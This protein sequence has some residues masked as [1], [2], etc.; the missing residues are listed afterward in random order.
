MH[1]QGERNLSLNKA[2]VHKVLID[3][4]EYTEKPTT[5]LYKYSKYRANFLGK[6]IY[7]SKLKIAQKKNMEFNLKGLTVEEFIHEVG[8]KDLKRRASKKEMDILRKR[9]KFT[10]QRYLT[11]NQVAKLVT[12]GQTIV[13]G[14]FKELNKKDQ[15]ING[16]FQGY[17]KS[18]EAIDFD[19]TQ[20]V[21]LDFDSNITIQE[22]ISIAEKN[23]LPIALLY[24]TFS[25]K[26]NSHKFRI[27]HQL[28]YKIKD[29]LTFKIVLKA[30]TNVYLNTQDGQVSS[31]INLIFGTRAKHIILDELAVISKE[32][33]HKLIGVMVP[34]VEEN[35]SIF[36]PDVIKCTQGVVTKTAK[37]IKSFGKLIDVDYK[38]SS[39]DEKYEKLMGK[40]Y[41]LTRF[42]QGAINESG[43]HNK[44][45]GIGW[46]WNELNLDMYDFSYIASLNRP[47][48]DWDS[49]IASILKKEH[50][51][52]F[53]ISHAI[54]KDL[55][56]LDFT[57]V[58][59]EIIKNDYITNQLRKQKIKDKVVRVKQEGRHIES[60]KSIIDDNLSAWDKNKILLI[61]DTG[62]G[63]TWSILHDYH[64]MGSKVCFI[65]PNT[66]N[67]QQIEQQYAKLNLQ[68]LYG[69]S[70][71][72]HESK[73]MVVTT[74]DSLR[75]V[76]IKKVFDII[77]Q[78]EIHTQL[79]A[80]SYRSE[81]IADMQH[82]INNAITVV[83]VTATPNFL[84]FPSYNKIIRI[85][86]VDKRDA[87]P[88]TIEISD[89]AKKFSEDIIRKIIKKKQLKNNKFLV[90]RQN[91]T[92]LSNVGEE[93]KFEEAV[94][95]YEDDLQDFDITYLSS[96]IKKDNP[97][98]NE[99]IDTGLMTSDVLVHTDIF[100]TGINI[101]NEETFNLFIVDIK[102]A[103]LIKQYI[104]R[105][106]NAVK[107][108]V[109]IYNY[110]S[111]ELEAT[112]ISR[113]MESY[114]D[115][116]SLLQKKTKEIADLLN[117][118]KEGESDLESK[119]YDSLSYSQGLILNP[120]SNLYEI[121]PL[122]LQFI[123]YN[124]YIT[125]FIKKDTGVALKEYYSDI[126]YITVAENEQ[127]LPDTYEDLEGEK[128]IY[129]LQNLYDDNIENP[130]IDKEL[131]DE[132]TIQTFEKYM[133]RYANPRISTLR[134][135]L[136]G[137]TFFQKYQ[138]FFNIRQLKKYK[139]SNAGLE[140]DFMV[141]VLKKLGRNKK[142][143]DKNKTRYLA[144][145]INN[146]LV[147]K[148]RITQVERKINQYFYKSP[149]KNKKKEKEYTYKL[150]NIDLLHDYLKDSEGYKKLDKN[151]TNPFLRTDLIQMIRIDEALFK[152]EFEKINNSKRIKPNNKKKKIA[153][154]FKK[155]R[156]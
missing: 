65:L 39:I 38:A 156:R 77:F 68:C 19:V 31:P 153:K 30:I 122:M 4:Y 7:E 144:T 16:V 45:L 59:E 51:T 140:I 14:A 130:N 139:I 71:K 124:N 154:L 5:F 87:I 120:I 6:S 148:L 53:D 86:K 102:D 114:Y 143:Y 35:I 49:E 135:S 107:V 24:P 137:S 100:S 27:I 55:K 72:Y 44:I 82:K 115:S 18:Q 13:M 133:S 8:V 41:W 58:H 50:Y 11:I 85:E 67:V 118:M 66:A 113:D 56:V 75:K 69:G 64:H 62:M 89:C 119:I 2:I 127:D 149:V 128:L 95:K 134:I 70:K 116:L 29:S 42:L 33:L 80:M 146:L 54:L 84:D 106:R 73:G 141:Q 99:I 37:V 92:W 105:F 40:N 112:K 123:V 83:D 142:V 9:L 43:T 26:P 150:Y 147:T 57:S 47:E 61:A 117:K 15:Y 36:E 108:N 111:E 46:A 81:A 1:K 32:T 94:K 10:P 109:T 91:K 17:I 23:N 88:V 131:I 22:A 3:D 48:Y 104:A 12:N 98:Y 78:D 79:Q 145:E 110:F 125:S 76:P 138:G 121:N 126:S 28:P 74:W 20:W 93:L 60:I 151:I 34:P 97:V 52:G 25:H 155:K 63:K 103:T 96:F 136:G 152:K 101:E 21:I 129:T 132:K 90:L